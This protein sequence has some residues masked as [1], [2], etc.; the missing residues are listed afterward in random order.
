MKAL[1]IYDSLYGNTEKVAKALASGIREQGIDVDCVRANTVD[2]ET[3]RAYDMILI[4]GPT[5]SMG[6]S[7]AIKTFTKQ[8]NNAEVKNKQAFA[9]DTKYESRFAGSAGKAI[10]QRLKQNG[11]KVVMPHAS[12]IVLGK[13]G[14]LKEGA[15]AQF[16]QIGTELARIALAP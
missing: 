10:E 3:L 1:V 15:E 4:G 2:V 16:K 11:L 9:F 6:L 12:A 14:P 13:E 7:D 5:H 8:L